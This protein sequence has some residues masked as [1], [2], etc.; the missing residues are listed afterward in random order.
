MKLTGSEIVAEMLVREGVPFAIGIP[1]HGNL[2]LVDAFRRCQ[3][4]LKVIMPRHEQAAV[5]MADGYYRVKG[6]PLAV[7]TSIGAGASNTAIGLATAYVD[8]IPLLLLIGET[9][10]YMRG[11]GVLQEIERQYWSDMPKMLYPT[12]KR[13]WHIDSAAQLQRAVA[14]A[15]NAMCTGRPGP[16]LITLPMDVQADCVELERAPD[17]RPRRPHDRPA[18]DPAAVAQAAERL[19][20]AERPVI[21][22][23]GG[24]ILAEAWDEL[25]AL[26]EHL[27]AA[28]VTTMQ[29]KSAFPED[30]PLYAW[31]MGA[32]ATTCGNSM[33]TRADVLLAVGVRF[34]D[35]AACSYKPGES[36][37]IPPTKLLHVDIDPFEIG[38]NY[39]V[40]VGIVGDA[41]AVLGQLVEAVRAR[42]APR[43][44][45]E[46]AYTR[47]IAERVQGWRQQSRALRESDKTPVNMGRALAE[48]RKVL[49]PEGIVLTSSGNVQA[50]VFQEMAFAKPRT[51]LAAGG[52]STMGWS[53]PAALG[54]KLAAP[55]APV[56]ALVG[57]GDF[58]MTI[59]EL[60]TAAQYNIPVVV[61]VL[62]NQGWQA[63][64]DLQVIAYGEDS[65]YATMFED[66]VEPLSPNL[67]DAAKAFGVHGERI[68]APGEVGP[69]L[70][71]AL[72]LG[73]PAVIEVMVDAELGTSG[74]L[75]PGWWDVPVPGYLDR[76]RAAYESARREEKV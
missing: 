71:R 57:D 52:F 46:S 27:G 23:G 15:F 55:D 34:A 22:A 40:E 7:F 65:V 49:P 48:V 36:F 9:H 28:V 13:A 17:A 11:V 41:K 38:K 70:E 72:R 67:A 16:A 14:Q 4:N 63:I 50:Q 53:F 2:A 60:A 25:R 68:S 26:A 5:H 42:S 73:K 47:E 21:V 30:H 18:G 56:V 39:P 69:A 3:D 45:Q 51:Y 35:K 54:A 12:V 19:L 29:G 33:T 64:R 66:G 61:V 58:L 75:A 24:V 44:W 76:R 59:Q 37:S 74:G 20:A 1:G 62:N 6:E 31:H 43:A 32:N 10:T 8:S